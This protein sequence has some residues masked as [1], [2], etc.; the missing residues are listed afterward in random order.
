MANLRVGY[1]HTADVDVGGC[2][3]TRRSAS[4]RDALLPDETYGCWTRRRAAGR[5]VQLLDTAYDCLTRRTTAER[6]I[7]DCW[8]RVL[9]LLSEKRTTTERETYGGW[10]RCTVAGR[11]EQ[12]LDE[13]YDFWSRC[14]AAGRVRYGC[15]GQDTQLTAVNGRRT[16]AVDQRRT[17]AVDETKTRSV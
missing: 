8:A 10:A 14:A 5:D 7:C 12:L 1:G 9:R 4:V 16:A 17:A 2:W 11:D 6:D 15:C 13:I 3:A